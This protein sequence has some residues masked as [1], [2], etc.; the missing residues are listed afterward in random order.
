MKLQAL[1]GKKKV[2][3]TLKNQIK[4]DPRLAEK[5]KFPMSPYFLFLKEMRANNIEKSNNL[6]TSK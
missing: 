2:K 6:Q 1:K 4:R 5:P 3:N